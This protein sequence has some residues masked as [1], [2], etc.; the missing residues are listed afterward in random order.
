LFLFQFDKTSQKQDSLVSFPNSQ[1]SQKQDSLVSFPNRKDK[2]KTNKPVFLDLF[3]FLNLIQRET[4]RGN[5][6]L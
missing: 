6:S 1:T 2:S 4:G 5:E 3:V